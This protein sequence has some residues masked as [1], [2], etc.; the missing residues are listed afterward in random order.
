MNSFADENNSKKGRGKGA[1]RVERGGW[2]S[3]FRPCEES[4]KNSSD[5]RSWLAPVPLLSAKIFSGI[6]CPSPLC[7]PTGS[8]GVSRR[9]RRTRRQPVQLKFTV[10][11]V[12]RISKHGQRVKCFKAAANYRCN[13]TDCIA[14]ADSIRHRRH[15]L[16]VN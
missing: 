9:K 1:V 3:L 13:D 4:A 7:F 16:L 11:K 14:I 12:I 5:T 10:E 2:C 6:A 15:A 8:H